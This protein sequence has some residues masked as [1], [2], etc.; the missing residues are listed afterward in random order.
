MSKLLVML[1]SLSL[2]ALVASGCN[3]KKADN[4]EGPMESAGEEVNQ[5]VEET[6]D[7]LEEAGD[8]IED[9]TDDATD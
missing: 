6:G 5:A 1:F 8:N 2:A 7:S 9:S 3:K 4:N